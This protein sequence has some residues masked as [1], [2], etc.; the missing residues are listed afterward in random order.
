MYLG[1]AG[2]CHVCSYFLCEL[3]ELQLFEASIVLLD[4]LQALGG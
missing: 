1:L 2:G 3:Q 4:A